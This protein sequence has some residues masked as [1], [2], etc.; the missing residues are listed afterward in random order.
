MAKKNTRDVPLPSS[1][2]MFGGPGDPKKK[3]G[4]KTIYTSDPKRV[5]AYND[6][7]NL[8]KRGK[9]KLLFGKNNPNATNAE[10]NTKED[11]IDKSFPVSKLRDSF[12]HSIIKSYGGLSI[13]TGS[14]YRMVD[15]YKEPV[16]PVVYKKAEKKK[17]TKTP[18]KVAAPKTTAKAKSISKPVEKAK[19]VVKKPEKI[20]MKPV[21]EEDSSA[22]K[23][24]FKKQT[25]KE[26][27]SKDSD[28]NKLEKKLGRKPTVAEYNKSIKK[29]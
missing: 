21:S 24:G 28:Y 23:A 18:A 5:Q 11:K 2:G 6:S 9:E 26:F 25:G 8:Y 7:L 19:P 1:D 12:G 10:L 16:Q 4:P 13:G 22:L 20:V 17:T 3:S 15:L 29:S 27:K 14:S